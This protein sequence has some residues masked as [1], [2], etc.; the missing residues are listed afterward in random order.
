L[1][2][3]GGGLVIKGVEGGFV[4]PDEIKEIKREVESSREG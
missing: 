1:F 2:S 3:L 4:G